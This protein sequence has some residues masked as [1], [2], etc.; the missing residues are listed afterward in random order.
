MTGKFLYGKQSGIILNG[1][2]E[3]NHLLWLEW[4][5]NVF[6]LLN[7][8]LQT[9]K[10][11]GEMKLMK[12]IVHLRGWTIHFLHDGENLPFL[13][14]SSAQWMLYDCHHSLVL[15]SYHTEVLI[16]RQQWNWISMFNLTEMCECESSV[17][18]HFYN[19]YW[20]INL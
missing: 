2:W 17:T 6:N 3:F 10:N 5:F 8:L 11:I 19:C 18:H 1:I 16:L 14:I 12:K 4:V 7:S 15:L 13:Y 20:V 9:V